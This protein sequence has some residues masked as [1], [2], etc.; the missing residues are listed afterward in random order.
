MFSRSLL[1]PVQAHSL[2]IR[3]RL[4]PT[5]RAASTSHTAD[6][7]T[8]EV[9]SSPAADPTIHRVDPSSENVQKPHEAPSGPWSATGVEAGVTNA[10][11][12][13]EEEHPGV[14]SR[15]GGKESYEKEKGGNP[16][17]TT[18][19][20]EKQGPQGSESG[21]RKPEGR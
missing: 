3:H 18:R 6:S 13:K 5:S 19:S 10:Q 17:E 9:D 15:Y 1:R 2:A 21:G 14:G 11:G 16:N 4:A 7:Y 12:A 8:K 20:T